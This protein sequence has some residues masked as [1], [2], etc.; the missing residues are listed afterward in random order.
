MADTKR[1]PYCAEQIQAEAIR[2]RYCRSRLT[3]FDA[4]RWHRSHPEARLGGVCAAVAHALAV[5]LAIV[6]IAFVALTFFHLY[7]D[8]WCTRHSG[9]S[10]QA[11]PAASPSWRDCSAGAVVWRGCSAE[12]TTG[13]TACGSPL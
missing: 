10:S 5:P 2:C 3:S 1:C 9:C 12:G 11:Y 13:R 4:D 8:R 6:R 7:L